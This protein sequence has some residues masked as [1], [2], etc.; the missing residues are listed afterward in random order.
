[1]Q[2]NMHK[3]YNCRFNIDRFHY[4]D[5]NNCPLAYNCNYYFDLNGVNTSMAEHVNFSLLALYG[6][7][8]LMKPSSYFFYVRD[9]LGSYNMKRVSSRYVTYSSKYKNMIKNRMARN[10]EIK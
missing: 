3:N 8:K 1:M 2:F 6:Q 9:Y 10:L 7:L 4:R 5:H